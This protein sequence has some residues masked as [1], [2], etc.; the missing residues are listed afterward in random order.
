MS[1]FCGPQLPQQDNDTQT[2]RPVKEDE[3]PLWRFW[4]ISCACDER[5]FPTKPSYDSEAE[6]WEPELIHGI[7][8]L[9]LA[10]PYNES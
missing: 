2:H 7:D 5:A 10:L 9:F 6:Q 4:E 1:N 8:R 3:R